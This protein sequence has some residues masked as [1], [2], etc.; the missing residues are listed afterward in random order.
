MRMLFDDRNNKIVNT[1]NPQ[2]GHWPVDEKNNIWT[3]EILH[4]LIGK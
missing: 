2:Y 4:S 3:E 1:C